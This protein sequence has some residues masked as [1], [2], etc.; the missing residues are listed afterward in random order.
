MFLADIK[1]QDAVIR[2][3]QTFCESTQRLPIKWKA[4][5]PET[6]WIRIAEFRIFLAHQYLDVDLEIVWNVATNYLPELKMTVEA[7][8]QEYWNQ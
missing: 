1:T 4:A 6:D 5:H 3:L 7:I 2:N 8:A